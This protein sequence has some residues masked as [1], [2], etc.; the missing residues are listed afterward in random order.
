MCHMKGTLCN[1]LK[2]PFPLQIAQFSSCWDE[3]R[4]SSL[5]IIY[6]YKYIIVYTKTAHVF[7]YCYITRVME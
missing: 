3:T 7:K 5:V 4:M 2:M 6:E 1:T